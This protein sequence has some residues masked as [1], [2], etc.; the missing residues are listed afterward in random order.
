MDFIVTRKELKYNCH[1][2]TKYIIMDF[3][4]KQNRKGNIMAKITEGYMPYLG[5]Q[6]YYRIV[7]ERKNNGKAPLICLHGGPG[8]THNYYE[9]LDNVADDDDRMIVM[10][11]QIGCGNSYLDGHPELWNQKVWLDE[12]DALRKHLG[13]DE[14]HI[15]GQSWGGMM[16]IAYA[17]DYKPQGVKSFIISSGH[18]SSSLWEREGLRRIKMMPQDMQDAINHALET[19]DFTGEA[20]D[21]AVAEYMDRYCNYWLGEDVPECCKRPKKSGSESYVEGWGPNE[22]A[23][24]GSLRDFEY[25]DRLGEIEIPSLICSGISDLCSPLVAKTMAD[26]IPN[27]KWI[28]WERARHTCFVDRH[29]DYCKELIKWMNQYD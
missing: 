27:S 28:L 1:L 7:G 20:Y 11:D 12:L 2:P 10:Y 23:P 14:C 18:P 8:S 19:G 24:T 16:Q 6:T 4:N 13:L 25:I 29:D 15:I 5:Y 26:G 22:F 17:I 21:A 3:L 9:V